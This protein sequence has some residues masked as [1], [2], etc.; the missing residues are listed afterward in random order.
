[1]GLLIQMVPVQCCTSIASELVNAGLSLCRC[2]SHVALSACLPA[3]LP[4][5]F[6]QEPRERGWHQQCGLARAE[7]DRWGQGQKLKN[8]TLLFY[9]KVPVCQVAEK[10]CCCCPPSHQKFS[11][12]SPGP[13]PAQVLLLLQL[14]CL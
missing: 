4:P 5:S 6:Q 13:C 9:S 1:M 3:L 7:Q 11:V 2:N 14:K 10:C 12:L 8:I